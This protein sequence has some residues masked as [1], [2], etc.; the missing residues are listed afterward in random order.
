MA[1]LDA[2]RL[3]A[4]AGQHRR[5]DP[6]IDAIVLGQQDLAAP[7]ARR[8]RFAD[9][10]GFGR[11]ARQAAQPRG[12]PL[13]RGDLV[14]LSIASDKADREKPRQPERVERLG[15][16]D[17]D[18]LAPLA[19]PAAAQPV[20]PQ[21]GRDRGFRRRR[22]RVA[23]RRELEPEQGA[24]AGRAFNPDAAAPGLK[25]APGDGEAEAAAAEA[26]RDMSGPAWTKAVE[27][28]LLRRLVDANAGVAHLEAEPDFAAAAAAG[29]GRRSPPRLTA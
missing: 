18:R 15:R 23:F 1:V 22:R 29:R 26:R 16:D 12:Q 10:G 6:A 21:H 25:P 19:A 4:A 14:G 20:Q 17:A 13:R 28:P 2:G 3:E 24:P 11:P 9:V 27:D 8:S 5:E 7:G